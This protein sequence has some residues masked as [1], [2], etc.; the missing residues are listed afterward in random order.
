MSQGILNTPGITFGNSAGG[1]LTAQQFGIT[2]KNSFLTPPGAPGSIYKRKVRRPKPKGNLWF[3]DGPLRGI[4]DGSPMEYQ[5]VVTIKGNGGVAYMSGEDTLPNT[6]YERH[7]Y[8][9][10][11]QLHSGRWVYSWV[12][13]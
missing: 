6:V 10:L 1:A 12:K 3:L 4:R 5:E 9:R 2:V 11:G 8:K 13:P 7:S